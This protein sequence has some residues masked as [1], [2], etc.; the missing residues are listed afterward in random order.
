MSDNAGMPPDPVV[1]Y[2]VIT[3]NRRAELADCLRNI[4]SQACSGIE[5]I[6]VDNG[7][8]DDTAKLVR[9][10][11]PGVRLL[12]CAANSGVGGGRNRAVREALGHVCVFVDDDARFVRDDVAETVL[13]SFDENPRLAAVAFRV[14]RAIDNAI[15]PRAIPRADKRHLD[16]DYLSTYFT[17]AGFAL[18]RDVF[19]EAGLFWEA[20]FYGGEELDLSYR[21]LDMGYEILCP[22]AIEV[23]HLDVQAEREPGQWVYYNARNRC[24]VATRNLPWLCVIS[25]TLLW[26]AKTFAVGIARGEFKYFVRGV[27]DSMLGW[28]EAKRKRHPIGAPARR[29]LRRRSGRLWY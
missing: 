19:I 20:L 12:R 1:S 7:S 3:R 25:T 17:G 15:D 26:W 23:L 22:Q 4:E 29:E 28:S 8:T 13:L 18:K 2:I 10:E 5:V 6:V 24:W 21:F 9:D 27:R 14:R 11:F 16:Q